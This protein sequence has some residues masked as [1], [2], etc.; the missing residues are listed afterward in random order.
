MQVMQSSDFKFRDSISEITS[1]L[2]NLKLAVSYKLV[3]LANAPPYY[4]IR[5]LYI[6]ILCMLLLVKASSCL[7]PVGVPYLYR[8]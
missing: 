2:N 8:I 5:I 4:F 3:P 1:K 7:T 6:L